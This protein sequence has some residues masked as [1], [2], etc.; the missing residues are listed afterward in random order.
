MNPL[1]SV[2]V[3]EPPWTYEL[4]I[5][6]FKA[7]LSYR[8]IGLHKSLRLV[9][10]LN[11]VNSTLS[12]TDTPLTLQDVK[13][14]LESLYNIQGLEEQESEESIAPEDFTEFELPFQD[15]V[16]IIED[17]SRAVEG[18]G[19]MPSSPEAVMSVRSGRSG[20]GRGT[21]RRRE[22]SS[23]V[24][25]TD[26]GTDDEGTF[27]F[28]V[29]L[30]VEFASPSAPA[31]T[32]RPRGASQR[33]ASASVTP[34]A[35]TAPKRRTGRWAKKEEE[36]GKEEKEVKEEEDVAEDEERE[37]IAETASVAE[38]D[39][40]PGKA[41][42]TSSRRKSGQDENKSEPPSRGVARGRGGRGGRARGRG[43]GRGH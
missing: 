29:G 25:N 34:A 30:H 20:G 8:P 3:P 26:A 12:A 32:K 5:A 40:G 41:L 14:K 11:A 24:S 23:V 4:E 18:D 7:I 17:R 21:K 38:T 9:S 43:R 33:K 10:I 35:S 27:H 31:R 15:V 13:S 36:E 39:T 42:R 6:L 28:E 37:S 2:D 22:E 16:G 19:S 1:P